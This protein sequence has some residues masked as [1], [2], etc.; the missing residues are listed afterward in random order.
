MRRGVDLQDDIHVYI[1]GILLKQIMESQKGQI[2]H[3]CS[4]VYVFFSICYSLNVNEKKML[5][6]N[7]VL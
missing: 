2:F 6:A 5:N 7:S 3:L 4:Y 1:E